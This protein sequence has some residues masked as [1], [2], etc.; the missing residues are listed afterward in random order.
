MTNVALLEAK[1]EGS[2]LKKTHIAEALGMTYANFW[3]MLNRGA[4]FKPSQIK[5]LCDL[6]RIVDPE[7]R[8]EI[9]LI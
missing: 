8:E 6:L 3:K 4:E 7:E 5:I 1:I 2:G 9:F